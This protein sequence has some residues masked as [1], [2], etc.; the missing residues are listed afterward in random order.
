M[1]G[2]TC[3]VVLGTSRYYIGTIRSQVPE[4]DGALLL[5]RL[6]GK[7]GLLPVL[8]DVREGELQVHVHRLQ[9]EVLRVEVNQCVQKH[10]I[11]NAL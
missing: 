2:S 11:H 5:P 10:L 1:V 9:L 8:H 4:Q 3:Q 7:V 6:V